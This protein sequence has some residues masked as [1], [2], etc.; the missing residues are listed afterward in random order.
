MVKMSFDLWFVRV[1]KLVRKSESPI[2]FEFK[3]IKCELVHTYLDPWSG[4]PM[5]GLIVNDHH[6]G[7]LAREVYESDTVDFFPDDHE[8]EESSKD[9]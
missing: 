4:F 2:L 7:A 5:L 6:F 1:G 9:S 8:S 3:G